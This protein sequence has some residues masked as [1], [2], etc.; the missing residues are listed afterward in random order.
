MPQYGLMTDVEVGIRGETLVE[1]WK[2]I[3][4]V[5]GLKFP[6]DLF[7]LT[8]SCAR[9]GHDFTNLRA[10]AGNL[11]VGRY[12][13]EWQ[14]ETAGKLRFLRVTF[15]FIPHPVR[16]LGQGFFDAARRFS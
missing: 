7:Y 15:D 5:V 2:E 4:A 16:V 9:D 1:G 8:D 12:I 14:K 11:P 10:S 13:A 3:I 6:H